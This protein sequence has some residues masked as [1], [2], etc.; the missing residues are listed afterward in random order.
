M[1]PNAD[2]RWPIRG[3]L[4]RTHRPGRYGAA[5]KQV[6]QAEVDAWIREVKAAG[7][8][9]VICLLDDA[10]LAYYQDL[11]VPGDLIAYYRQNGLEVAHVPTRNHAPLLQEQLDAAWD[12]CARLPRPLVVHCS[13]GQ[14]RTGKVI[15][16]LKPRLR[17]S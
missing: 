4:A 7:I 13:A 1:N 3:T 11:P 15:R 12:A 10:Q 16:H 17:G 8:R 9:S 5:P 14:T 2:I 6:P